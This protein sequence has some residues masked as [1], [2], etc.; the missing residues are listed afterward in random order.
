MPHHPRIQIKLEES[1]HVQEIK[2]AYLTR[3]SQRSVETRA[4]NKPP[5]TQSQQGGDAECDA[6]WNGFRL[7]PEGDPGHDHR[8]GRGHI[9][10]EQMVPE[11]PPQVEHHRQARKVS[12][13]I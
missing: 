8:D 10:V 2:V 7:D 4:I 5:R 13:K 6:G 3:L 12:C 1:T 9:R 11:A